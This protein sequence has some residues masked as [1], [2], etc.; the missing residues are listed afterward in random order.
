MSCCSSQHSASTAQV[1]SEIMKRESNSSTAVSSAASWP[2][3]PGAAPPSVKITYEACDAPLLGEAEEEKTNDYDEENY[4]D[5]AEPAGVAAMPIRR[6]RK[7]GRAGGGAAGA[8]RAP[9]GEDGE[10]GCI[11]RQNIDVK[12]GTAKG[13]ARAS[14][15]VAPLLP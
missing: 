10:S 9:A 13:M 8:R 15:P 14:F 6:R 3:Q 7:E 12:S 1:A 11:Q 5:D 4:E 2:L